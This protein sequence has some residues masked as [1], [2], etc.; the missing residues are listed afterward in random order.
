MNIILAEVSFLPDRETIE[1]IGI[2][3]NAGAGLISVLGLAGA[4]HILKHPPASPTKGH[5]SNVR[6]FMFTAMFMAVVCLASG[7]YVGRNNS[8]ETNLARQ[9]LATTRMTLTNAVNSLETEREA[10]K[11][12]LVLANELETELKTLTS[13]TNKFV[14]T[15]I[16]TNLSFRLRDIQNQSFKLRESLNKS[17]LLEA[18]P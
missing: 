3:A 9:N 7:I 4:F 17:V 5:D 13:A 14:P 2:W 11:G 12:I 1:T 6:L 15:T 10:T 18:K 16:K 8:K